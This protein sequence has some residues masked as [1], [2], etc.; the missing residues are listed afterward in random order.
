ML[1]MGGVAPH[2]LTQLGLALPF[3]ILNA[4]CKPAWQLHTIAASDFRLCVHGASN[5][6]S[7]LKGV[8]VDFFYCK[9]VVL[10]VWI[11]CVHERT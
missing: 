3:S 1:G 9:T 7:Q 5:E 2:L 11:V 4:V 6:G 10:F 8:R